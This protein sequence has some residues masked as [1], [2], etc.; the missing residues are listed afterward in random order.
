MSLLLVRLVTL[1]CMVLTVAVSALVPTT[2]ESDTNSLC[3]AFV[4]SVETSEL[5]AAVSAL[6][7][8]TVVMDP[9][10]LLLL[11]SAAAISYS[12]S[13]FVGAFPIT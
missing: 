12:V 11:F 4:D 2:V 6:L 3:V 7:A 10:K 9:A 8:K 13:R 5:T 1:I